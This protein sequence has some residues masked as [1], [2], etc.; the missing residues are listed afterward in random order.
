MVKVNKFTYLKESKEKFCTG[1]KLLSEDINFWSNA[2][3][4]GEIDGLVNNGAQVI[5]QTESHAVLVRDVDEE[6]YSLYVLSFL[7]D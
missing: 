6:F 7:G 2:T 5:S 1:N 4:Q 3:L